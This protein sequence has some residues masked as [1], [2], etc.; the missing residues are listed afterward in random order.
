M[1]GYNPPLGTKDEK[2][3][4]IRY[5]A[6]GGVVRAIPLAAAIKAALPEVSL[7]WLL[8][9]PYEELIEG[10]PYVGDL[11]VWDR[12]LGFKGFV[13]LILKIRKA[14]FTHMISMQGTDRSAVIA[15]FQ[16]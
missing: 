7:T 12:K 8:V 2:I 13:R 6:L 1:A 16:A 3:L 14:N 9:H 10:Q 11:L 4:F 5:S 15:F